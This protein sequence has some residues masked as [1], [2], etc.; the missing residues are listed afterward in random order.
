MAKETYHPPEQPHGQVVIS[1]E[2][3]GL[4]KTLSTDQ[5]FDKFLSWLDGYI[6]GLEILAPDSEALKTAKFIRDAAGKL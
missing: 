3:A 2:K 6:S 5:R 4:W 1:Q